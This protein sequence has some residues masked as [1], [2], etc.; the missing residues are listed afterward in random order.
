MPT[1]SRPVVVVLKVILGLLVVALLITIVVGWLFTDRSWT[2]F[3]NVLFFVGFFVLLFGL[4]TPEGR[5]GTRPSRVMGLSGVAAGV[6]CMVAG[7]LLVF[8]T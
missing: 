7:G 2:R 6:I 1:S 3:G 4:F 5:E 8:L